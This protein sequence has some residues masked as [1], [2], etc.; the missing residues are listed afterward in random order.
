[1][2]EETF[3]TAQSCTDAVLIDERKNGDALSLV[4]H[5]QAK[6]GFKKLIMDVVISE[7]AKAR[8]LELGFSVDKSRDGRGLITWQ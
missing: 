7:G 3:K 1:M 4:C 8:L 5:E 2:S 6:K